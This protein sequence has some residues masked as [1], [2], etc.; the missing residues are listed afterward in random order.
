MDSTCANGFATKPRRGRQSWRNTIT[1]LT[2]P[3]NGV[4]R[5]LDVL[6]K[7]ILVTQHVTQEMHLGTA[8]IPLDT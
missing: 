3:T 2:P 1:A 4:N 8:D 6:Y 7:N 5:S